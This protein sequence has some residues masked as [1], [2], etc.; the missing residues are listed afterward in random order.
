MTNNFRFRIGLASSGD[1]LL[2]GREIESELHLFRDCWLAVQVWRFLTCD[3]MPRDFYVDD[4][5]TWLRINLKDRSLIRGCK[6]G[7]LFGVAIS[8][9]WQSRNDFIFN[10]NRP[11]GVGIGKRILS[12]AGVISAHYNDSKRAALTGVSAMNRTHIRWN[13]PE[14]GVVKVNVDGAVSGLGETAAVGG[15]MRNY[16][17]EFLFGFAF[18]LGSGT[19]TEPELEAIL[20]GISLARTHGQ[21]RV[22]IESDSLAAVNL[23]EEG[24]SVQHCY[25]NLLTDIR[26][27]LTE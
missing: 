1:C 5:H 3:M 8:L 27:L 2:C 17:G 4:L 18:H 19:T 14:M 21:R 22:I 10:G 9:I 11:S 20:M 23:I 25:F 13:A 12:Q 6:W 15:V 16:R 26:K 7:I 24:V